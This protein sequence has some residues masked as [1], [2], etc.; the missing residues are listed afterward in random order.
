MLS[1]LL[2]VFLTTFTHSWRGRIEAITTGKMWN[3]LITIWQRSRNNVED[4]VIFFVVTTQ[5]VWKPVRGAR[6]LA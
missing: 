5:W 3:G 1:K 4:Y 2:M 6:Y